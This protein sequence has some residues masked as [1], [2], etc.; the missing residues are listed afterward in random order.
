MGVYILVA[1]VIIIWGSS[2][3]VARLLLNDISPYTLQ[4]YTSITA[5][6]SSTAILLWNRKVVE[7][8][9]LKFK[10]FRILFLMGLLG[11]FLYIM[12]FYLA[13]ERLETQVA[14]SINY[15]WPLMTVIT[16]IIILKEGVSIKKLLAIIISFIAV[17]IIIT[18]GN[19]GMF[20][21]IDF[22][23]VLFGLGAAITY[24]LF[25]TLNRKYKY[26]PIVANF[27]FTL[28]SLLLNLIRYFSIG[29]FYVPNID[30]LLGIVWMGVFVNAVAFILWLKAIQIGDMSKIANLIYLTPFV[31]L[32]YIYFFLNE[33]IH[34]TSILG[35]VIIVFS[36]L[37]QNGTLDR[38]LANMFKRER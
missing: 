16:S 15:L 33:A 30:Q 23:G 25:S 6:M 18:K 11:T 24:G 12:F 10:D 32:V 36:I 21:T 5:I 9:S 4:T 14:Y 34:I 19:V 17:T 27:Y 2:P 26:D 29:D 8:V 22:I 37:W 31:S 7:A 35:L 13:V 28:F 38:F 3:T 20:A 1:F